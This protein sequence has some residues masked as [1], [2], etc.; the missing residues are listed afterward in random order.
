MIATTSILV[1]TFLIAVSVG[2][3]G[4][5][6]FGASTKGV[7]LY[8]LPND[9]PASIF[10][11]CA[12]VLTICGSFVLIIQPIFYIMESSKWYSNLIYSNRE[13]KED[14]KEEA[15]EMDPDQAAA[16]L[17]ADFDTVQQKDEENASDQSDTSISCG[18]WFLF[19]LFRILIVFTIAGLSFL[20]PNIHILL[21]LAG[22]VLGTLVNI[23][24]PVLFYNKAYNWSD[25]N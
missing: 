21:T 15:K 9:D 13:P 14:K 16:N 12:Y 24:L 19:A 25:K 4:Y 23:I 11:K 17:S 7:I 3:I 1:L 6:A 22:S 8:N 10:A 20:I 2:Y 5:L 18:K